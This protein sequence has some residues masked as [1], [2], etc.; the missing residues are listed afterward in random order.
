MGG[1]ID[2]ATV[3]PRLEPRNSLTLGTYGVGARTAGVVSEALNLDGLITVRAGL[4]PNL[5]D[6]LDTSVLTPTFTDGLAKLRWR[7]SAATTVTGEALWSRDTAAAQDT[8]RGEF[9][10]LTS[11]ERY[12]WLHGQ[13][14]ASEAWRVDA[15]LG[16]S[17]LE[18]QR[19][20]TVDNPGV[21]SGSAR[22]TATPIC[23]TCAGVAWRHESASEHRIWRRMEYRGC[24]LFLPNAIAL[25][26]QMAQLYQK[27]LFSTLTTVISPYRRD[28]ALYG[29]WRSRIGDRLTS[30]WGIRVQRSSGLGLEATWLWDPRAMLNWELSTDTRLRASWGRFHQAEN[31][32]ELDVEDGARDLTARRHPTTI[33]GT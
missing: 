26:P 3:D 16:Y 14:W 1:V 12:F 13:Q 31:A 30:E 20:G 27:P 6:R 15:W 25:A 2:L 19:N 7:P 17:N 32:Q 33:S 5:V 8:V 10:R 21:V 28:A 29:A 24:G 18:L 4:L 9:A 22:T 11:R 23:G